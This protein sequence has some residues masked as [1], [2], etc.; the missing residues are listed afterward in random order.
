[1]SKRKRDSIEST[2]DGS[3]PPA[4]DGSPPPAK[5][6]R[7]EP[8]T[9]KMGV[10]ADEE[11]DADDV[12][13]EQSQAQQIDSDSDRKFYKKR[14][15]LTKAFPGPLYQCLVALK[16]MLE[17]YDSGDEDFKIYMELDDVGAFDD[18]VVK[19]KGITSFIQVKYKY[20]NNKKD[21]YT[22][23]DLT[24]DS[25]DINLTDYFDYWVL[26]LLEN[27]MFASE[28]KRYIF[29]A[30]GQM[31]SKL[32]KLLRYNQKQGTYTIKSPDNFI[33]HIRDKSIVISPH[34]AKKVEPKKGKNKRSGTK[35]NKDDKKEKIN[36]V[37]WNK[38]HKNYEKGRT[39]Y[40]D[41]DDDKLKK[42]KEFL[43]KFEMQFLG[44]HIDELEKSL[45]QQVTKIFGEQV[46]TDGIF[47]VLI[48]QVQTWFRK[49]QVEPWN[50]S[51]VKKELDACKIRYKDLP[52]HIG[53]TKYKMMQLLK[54]N[55]HQPFLSDDYLNLYFKKIKDWLEDEKETPILCCHDEFVDFPTSLVVQFFL[56]DECSL[57]YGQY[58]YCDDADE[59]HALEE[60]INIKEI[61]VIIIR[62]HTSYDE[63]DDEKKQWIDLVLNKGKKIVLVS[64]KM[65]ASTEPALKNMKS[66]E[67]LPLDEK[68]IQEI[69]EK[70]ST[71]QSLS[72]R[73]LGKV[74]N[75]NYLSRNLSEEWVSVL[76]NPAHLSQM[77]LEAEP[78]DAG[79]TEMASPLYTPPAIYQSWPTHSL[80]QCLKTDGRWNIETDNEAIITEIK[81]ICK[82]NT[83]VKQIVLT[84]EGRLNVG[85]ESIL[86]VFDP[87]GLWVSTEN[88]LENMDKY[89]IVIRVGAVSDSKKFPYTETFT[90]E[91]E[92][93]D[94]KNGDIL[95][96]PRN[97]PDA[98]PDLHIKE[99][100]LRLFASDYHEL[101]SKGKLKPNTVIVAEAGCG[102]SQL[103]RQLYQDICQNRFDQQ[104]ENCFYWAAHI[105]LVELASN[106]LPQD[107]EALLKT[108]FKSDIETPWRK[109]LLDSIIEQKR[110]LFLLDGWDEL[111][112][113]YYRDGKFLWRSL[114]DYGMVI[115]FSRPQ[116]VK[117]L[118]VLPEFQQ[119]VLK[120]FNGKAI[121]DYVSKRFYEEK[122]FAEMANAYLKENES[123]KQ[124]VKLPLQC[125]LLCESWQPYYEVYKRTKD[126]HNLPWVHGGDFTPLKLYQRFVLAKLQKFLVDSMRVTEVVP[127][128]NPEQVYL[129]CSVYIDFLKSAGFRLLFPDENN[130]DTLNKFKGEVFFNGLSRIGLL[131]AVKKDAH[132]TNVFSHQTY[133]EYFAALYIACKLALEEESKEIAKVIR[134]QRY[135][136]R[137]ELVWQFVAMIVSYGDLAIPHLHMALARFWQVL[138]QSPR[139]LIGQRESNLFKM[140]LAHTDPNLL[141]E[142]V[143]G[144]EW[145]VK[146]DK[147]LSGMPDINHS[148][149]VDEKSECRS[150]ILKF[151]PP[152]VN[153]FITGR[154]GG[155]LPNWSMI[156][157]V[158]REEVAESYKEPKVRIAAID[159][160]LK[161]A[162]SNSQS[163]AIS[164]DVFEKLTNYDMNNLQDQNVGLIEQ[165]IIWFKYEYI[166][167]QKKH[168]YY[169]KEYLTAKSILA[170]LRIQKIDNLIE[171]LSKSE[172]VTVT[173]K[174]L[175]FHQ[176]LFA[177]LQALN[178]DFSNKLFQRVKNELLNVSSYME[179]V[180][181]V[182]LK[183]CLIQS[184]STESYKSSISIDRLLHSDW[185]NDFIRLALCHCF[186]DFP[187]DGRKKLL[188]A[189]ESFC[190]EK[191]E[192]ANNASL[193][194]NWLKFLMNK[195]ENPELADKLFEK[196]I[197]TPDLKDETNK[198]SKDEIKSNLADDVN[199][200]IL[201][202]HFSKFSEECKGKLI[203][204]L[205]SFCLILIKEHNQ[206][207]LSP[208]TSADWLKLL[209]DHIA[210][211]DAIW[212]SLFDPKHDG[213]HWDANVALLFIKMF[214]AKANE[215]V[216]D[217]LFEKFTL[218]G[219][220]YG[221]GLGVEAIKML[222]MVLHSS[223]IP[224]DRLFKRVIWNV[225]KYNSKVQE[226]DP[227]EYNL[228]LLYKLLRTVKN[229]TEILQCALQEQDVTDREKVTFLIDFCKAFDLGLVAKGH[230][231]YLVDS[232]G[233]RRELLATDLSSI[234][235]LLEKAR[236][237]DPQLQMLNNVVE[238]LVNK[239]SAMPSNQNNVAHSRAEALD[240]YVKQ[241]SDSRFFS[242][243][244][245][246]SSS[247]ME[248]EPMEIDEVPDVSSAAAAAKPAV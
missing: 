239:S 152:D 116:A 56:S 14:Y 228:S 191:G 155:E 104:H 27:P 86:V 209:S 169:N 63:L 149:S 23:G 78:L 75:L 26:F 33:E 34:R 241:S 189:V 4:E 205:E 68:E 45:K 192:E 211:A 41:N 35:K 99:K 102:K 235:Q 177:A 165:V 1:M 92:N 2:E 24:N 69:L 234:I 151:I 124:M 197:F 236:R 167:S 154:W 142:P 39:K 206:W 131:S 227:L 186:F 157:Y 67:L 130:P 247:P 108:L 127:L 139:D 49:M 5:K 113:V 144:P 145:R 118:S 172:S 28:K 174:R 89:N 31:N 82:G 32:Q 93:E 126:T 123:L 232:A 112:D 187:P 159:W 188:E 147:S 168:P 50:L 30:S 178:P 80:T 71:E 203:E 79:V 8:S 219:E 29:R 162:R 74:H 111:L 60:L 202:E 224:G 166:T 84:G 7:I 19:Q 91:L 61:R 94:E 22:A 158:I 138:N 215:D 173:D 243:P 163:Y 176:K 105:S 134:N 170:R 193:S 44:E 96:N 201:V 73:A 103:A 65:P 184:D 18:I 53:I 77:L 156:A 160:L 25:G 97:K 106:G 13:M 171:A 6:R 114:A 81:K 132:T 194:V 248:I 222:R 204:A 150:G 10:A 16:Y 15:N 58:F 245:A 117:K 40:F 233:E 244:P 17:A 95:L 210:S 217:Y 21:Q 42:I 47:H 220:R 11:K 121:A 3:P 216:C 180:A 9:G 110:M 242:P 38:V 223:N 51:R 218:T 133:A 199:R 72:V 59:M 141:T 208:S 136:P 190:D 207:M 231:L 146:K 143:S 125:Y 64:N 54:L 161:Q 229:E 140:C 225:L 221:V 101:A 183:R 12:P 196:L 240:G 164:R 200:K 129:F 88:Q 107:I 135:N 213:G 87:D 182:I 119:L 153:Y 70:Y 62:L 57:F 181:C 83:S 212:P 37:T 237:A 179:W 109:R 90:C 214:I 198:E 122:Q 36:H 137:Y 100:K 246:S 175:R 128:Q 230:I 55:R 120:Q 66:L 85:D 52:E 185:E 98:M 195:K 20:D 48:V 148:R 76:K 43:E 226:R 238:S 46:G 115:L